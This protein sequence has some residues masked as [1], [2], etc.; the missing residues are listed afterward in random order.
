MANVT[1]RIVA[2]EVMLATDAIRN[3]IREAKTPQMISVMQTGAQYGMKTLDQAL[4]ELYRKGLISLE[5]TLARCHDPETV[6]RT[7]ARGTA[8]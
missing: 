8:R 5:E 4:I 6:K 3:L 1:G 7:I 2:V